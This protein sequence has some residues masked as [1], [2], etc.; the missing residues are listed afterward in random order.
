MPNTI[1]LAKQF[2]PILDEVYQNERGRDPHQRD[3]EV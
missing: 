2:V 3:G 1:E